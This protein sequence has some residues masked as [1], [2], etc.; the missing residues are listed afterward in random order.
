MSSKINNNLINSTINTKIILDLN[1]EEDNYIKNILNIYKDIISFSDD[2]KK[3]LNS[4]I[5]TP[6]FNSDLQ[7]F[8]NKTYYKCINNFDNKNLNI[9][10]RNRSI[11]LNINKDINNIFNIYDINTIYDTIFNSIGKN[12][13]IIDIF[14]K[15]KNILY[16]M[17]FI[18]NIL[19]TV[20]QLKE[21]LET[22]N[23]NTS[24][25]YSIFLNKCFILNEILKNISPLIID[26]KYNS[27][28]FNKKINSIGEFIFEIENG[29]FIRN[30]QI[31]FLKNFN[32]DNN[33]NVYQLL[34]GRGKSS[35]IT[36]ILLLDYYF[37]NKDKNI[38][39]I[40]PTNPLVNSTFN[41]II[42]YK[43]YIDIDINILDNKFIHEKKII[44]IIT[45]V[46]LKIKFLKNIIHKTDE[47]NKD[48]ESSFCII[49]EFDSII[50]PS[51]SNLNIV[52]NDKRD[53]INGDIIFNILFSRLSSNK[54]ILP[55]N[56]YQ[57]IQ[58]HI[59]NIII[60]I[61]N[62][63]YR[64]N[65]GFGDLNFKKVELS[66]NNNFF[67]AVP[68]LYV[69]EPINGSK[70]SD[71][72]I[73]LGTTIQSYLKT[74]LRLE[75]IKLI[76]HEINNI[77]KKNPY[78][79]ILDMLYPNFMKIFNDKSII[80]NILNNYKIFMKLHINNFY[81]DY[82]EVINNDI[83]IIKEYLKNII[84]KSFFKVNNEYYNITF[85]DILGKLQNKIMFSGTVDFIIPKDLLKE[86]NVEIVPFTYFYNNIIEDNFSK[87]SIKNA[88]LGI[89]MNPRNKPKIY[90]LDNYNTGNNKES[91]F[92]DFLF[93]N[94]NG[95]LKDYEALI[96]VAGYILSTTVFNM[97]Q[98][99]YKYFESKGINKKILYVDT[100]NKQKIYY[101]G[102][103]TFYK[104]EIFKQ[105][106]IFIYYNNKNTIGIDFKQPIEMKGLV[107][108]DVNN[109][110][111]N[112]AQGM[113]RLRKLNITHTIDFYLD[114]SLKKNIVNDLDKLY[115]FLLNNG[116]NK[117]NNSE[118]L[119]IQQCIN[120]INKYNTQNIN[121][122]YIESSFI[123]KITIL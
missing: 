52:N 110:L 96:D 25:L 106:E 113:F 103:I 115:Q 8:I 34:M 88:I 123:K 102:N 72:E 51:K 10:S 80:I 63:T 65:Y 62:L 97:V 60:Y 27:N 26:F 6:L 16:K 28:N 22:S 64:K 4:K 109:T 47:F 120:Y 67:T 66:E 100:D 1:T 85:L 7:N 112:V 111:T 39:I 44:G 73:S 99:I 77:Y 13:H 84:F 59:E 11:H 36:P 104:N 5:N 75:D 14:L 31:E 68:Y 45:D 118:E 78:I 89:L 83:Y 2:I 90:Y 53:H 33:L 105:H 79:D 55:H 117:K 41:I 57:N 23:K 95:K 17:I 37:K 42:N 108:I 48:L 93:D 12:H 15:N 121:N 46:N 24:S 71:F 9:H 29:F 87:G 32:N 81:N 20:E 30:D 19:Y 101:N 18:R 92:N 21:Y 98:K 38:F 122:N 70:F 74:R 43:K 54:N 114:K 58:S 107:T 76:F 91:N 40:L 119:L 69:D 116:K 56:K 61:N 3:K 50:D 49:D 82:K 35:T 94:D 86:K